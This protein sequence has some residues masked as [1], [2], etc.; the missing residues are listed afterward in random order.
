MIERECIRTD[1][2]GE[3]M[4]PHV[5]SAKVNKLRVVRRD[6]VKETASREPRC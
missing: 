5:G 2:L 1:G 6:D 4:R 3:M